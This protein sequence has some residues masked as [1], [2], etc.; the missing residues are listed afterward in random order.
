MYK[1]RRIGA[2]SAAAFALVYPVL[3]VVMYYI[4]IYTYVPVLL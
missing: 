2:A 4:C 1:G 3:L